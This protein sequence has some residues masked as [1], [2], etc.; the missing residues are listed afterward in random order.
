MEK[1]AST[2]RT[3]FLIA[4]SCAAFVL[5]SAFAFRGWLEHGTDIFLAMAQN[6]MAWCL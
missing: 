5:L 3:M 4:L 2:L 1:E 6:G